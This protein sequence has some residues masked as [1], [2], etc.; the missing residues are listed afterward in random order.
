MQLLPE[1]IPFIRSMHDNL[2]LD[3]DKQRH[4]QSSLDWVHIFRT[5]LVSP[6]QHKRQKRTEKRLQRA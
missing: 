6:H 2:A 5:D 1:W 4:L 3:A